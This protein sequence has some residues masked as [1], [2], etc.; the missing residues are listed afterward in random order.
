MKYPFENAQEM[1]KLH[2]DTFI[3]PNINALINKLNTSLDGLFVKVNCNGERFWVDVTEYNNNVITGKV[4][5]DLVLTH[6]HN[7]QC[8]DIIT[9]KPE[10]VYTWDVF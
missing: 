5:N 1:E 10:N 4:N 8:G 3:A 6:K 2:P 7:L 9:F